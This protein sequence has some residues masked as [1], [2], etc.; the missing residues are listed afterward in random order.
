[1]YSCF[2]PANEV[3][4]R[5]GP[6][7]RDSDY[8]LDEF[9]REYPDS[10]RCLDWLWRARFA[11]DG[12]HA[13]CPRCGRERMFHRTRSRAAYTC[14]SCGLHV[15]PMKGTIFE[16][17]RVPLER[18]FYAIYL[19]G[20]PGGAISISQLERELGVTHRTARRIDTAIRSELLYQ[21]GPN[22]AADPVQPS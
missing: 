11:P 3:N 22:A 14:D 5:S 12:R 18:W 8:T 21:G 17:T 4:D 9:A 15:H 13:L 7:V 19:M 20:A 1:M 10:D 16:N 6:P 2:V